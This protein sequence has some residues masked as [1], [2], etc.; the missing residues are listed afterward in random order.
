MNEYIINLE[1]DRF[2]RI[3]FFQKKKNNSVQNYLDFSFKN[4]GDSEILKIIKD[5]YSSLSNIKTLYLGVNNITHYGSSIISNFLIQNNHLQ[6]LS[7]ESNSIGD[8]GCISLANMLQKNNTLISLI[9]GGNNIGDAGIIEISKSLR[10]NCSLK[11]L[12]LVNNNFSHSCISSIT[13]TLKL[14]TTLS[15][16]SLGFRLQ[17]TVIK[18]L[19]RIFDVNISLL[20]CSMEFENPHDGLEFSYN[21]NFNR[22]LECQRKLLFQTPISLFIHHFL[23]IGYQSILSCRV[24]PSEILFDIAFYSG[25]ISP[26]FIKLWEHESRIK[27]R[28]KY[29]LIYQSI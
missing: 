26:I 27:W 22:F 15:R 2:S 20:D 7:L 19:N 9:I 14:N 16:L 29:F 4:L 24:I 1:D 18:D 13:E 23:V 11:N 12:V 28:K 10:S 6:H 25:V 21:L 3:S 17:R 8:I 5:N